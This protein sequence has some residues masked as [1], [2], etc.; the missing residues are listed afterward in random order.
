MIGNADNSGADTYT[1]YFS[2]PATSSALYFCN[3]SDVAS[4]DSSATGYT[5]AVAVKTMDG[6]SFFQASSS[7]ALSNN[8]PLAIVATDNSNAKIAVKS[9]KFEAK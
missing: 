6:R 4:C 1:L 2:A 7:T 3:V 9:V 8:M 5:R